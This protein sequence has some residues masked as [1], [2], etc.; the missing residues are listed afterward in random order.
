MS[1]QNRAKQF[2]PFSAIKGLSKLLREKEKEHENFLKSK[3]VW[4]KFEDNP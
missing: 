1:R 2:A 3:R 4:E